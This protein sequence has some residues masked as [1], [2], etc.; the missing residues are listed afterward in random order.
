MAMKTILV[1]IP[2]TAVDTAAIEIALMVAK[3]VRGHIEGLYIETPAPITVRTGRL[4]GYQATR[5]VGLA[6]AAE[7]AQEDFARAAEARE[8]AAEQ[9]R[10]EFQRICAAHGVPVC[11]PDASDPVPSASWRQTEGSYASA[12]TMRAPAYDLMVVPNP[13]TTTPAREIAE[14]TLLETGRPVLLSPARAEPDPSSSAMIAW[15][16]SLQAWRAVAA[17]VPLM[18]TARQVEIVSVGED[19]A[20]VAESRADVIRYLGWHGITA[21]ARLI[22]PLSRSVGDTLLHEASEAG[23]GMLVMGAYSHSRMRELLLGGV[24]RHVLSSVAATPVFMAH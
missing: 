15:S 13:S 24:T 22:K 20:A 6:P 1:P 19:E 14:H 12:V 5:D 9:A 23:I 10:A 8:R 3:A 11:A 7:R 16:P 17:A 21:T 18:A 4:G 2:D